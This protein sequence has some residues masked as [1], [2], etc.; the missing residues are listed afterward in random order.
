MVFGTSVF[1]NTQLCLVVRWLTTTRSKKIMGCG[2]YIML[3]THRFMHL[4]NDHGRIG[5]AVR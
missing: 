1:K 3:K 5:K 4:E 2:V